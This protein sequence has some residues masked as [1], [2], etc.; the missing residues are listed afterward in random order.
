MLEPKFDDYMKPILEVMKDSGLRRNP[1][2][3]ALVLS[4]MKLKKEDFKETQKNGN[5]KYSDNINFAISYL[6]MAGL[7]DRKARGTYQI[8]QEGLRVINDP[9]IKEIN[10]KF[11]R[12]TY[13][14][15]KER[16]TGGQKKKS[17]QPVNNNPDQ[18]TPMEKIDEAEKIIKESVKNELL[19]AIKSLDPFDF[20]RLCLKFLLA[21]GYGYDESAGDVTKKSGDGGIDGIIFGDKLG[22]EKIAY[23]SKLWEGTVGKP[24]VSQFSSDFDYKQC[25]KGVFIT[26]SKF[27]AEAI[28]FADSKKNLILIDGDKLTDLMYENGIGVQ[29]RTVIKI[30]DIDSEFFEELE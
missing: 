18:L 5:M 12:D 17:E 28:K 25:A 29:T 10:E 6:F 15:F 19:A 16:V 27:S 8:T 24:E 4:Y 11:L 21:L 22:L 7:L 2:I 9:T 26:T 20:E 3:K 1:E 14:E 30:K 23:Q 13:P